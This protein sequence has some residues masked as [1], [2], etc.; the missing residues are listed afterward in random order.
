M[1]QQEPTIG[2]RVCKRRDP[3]AA[4]SD[5]ILAELNQRYRSTLNQLCVYF[6]EAQNPREAALTDIDTS[7]FA[8]SYTEQP[9]PLTDDANMADD[10]SAEQDSREVRVVFRHLVQSEDDIPLYF[11]ELF[12]EARTGIVSQTMSQVPKH[13]QLAFC[14]P[15][16]T[17]G[18]AIVLGLALVVYLNFA[19]N[20][21]YPL[22]W[23]QAAIGKKMLYLIMVLALMAH[24]FEALLAAMTCIAIMILA[25][26]YLTK[27]V[28]VQYVLGTLAFGFPVLRRLLHTI[29]YAFKDDA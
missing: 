1:A 8:I 6:G 25:P 21:V 22:D 28:A 18:S 14:P 2:S 3:I 27:S 17:L 4:D 13:R 19:K 11:A 15:P 29:K 9:Q 16:L 26:N 10:G 5:R 24:V 12:D 7:G 20:P 23:L